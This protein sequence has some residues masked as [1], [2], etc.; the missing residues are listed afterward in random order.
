[1]KFKRTQYWTIV[2]KSVCPTNYAFS[3]IAS[4]NM[5]SSFAKTDKHHPK[6]ELFM[7]FCSLYYLVLN[8]KIFFDKKQQSPVCLPAKTYAILQKLIKATFAGCHIQINPA[9]ALVGFCKWTL[10]MFIEISSNVNVNFIYY[11]N[12]IL[13]NDICGGLRWI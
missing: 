4:Q 3:L 11:S 12:N 6:I 5:K 13:K 9:M 10:H 8:V 1:M 7:P 2:L